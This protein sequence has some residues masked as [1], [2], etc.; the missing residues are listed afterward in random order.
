MNRSSP[1]ESDVRPVSRTRFIF[2]GIIFVGGFL[3]PLLIPLVTNSNLPGNWK[4]IL[5]TGLVAGLPEIGMLLAV[6][7][8]GKQ[9][10]AQLKE[11][12]FARFRKITEPAAVSLTRYR[13]GLFMLFTPLLLGWLQPYATHF[14]SSMASDS[15]L[16]VIILDLIFAT[17][18]IVLGA[19]FWGKIQSLFVHGGAVSSHDNHS[20]NDNSQGES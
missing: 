6:A 11:M 19:E 13:I 17:S 4:A 7:I 16:P 15:I 12:A 9:G 18:F 1:G 5:S 20:S 8:L 10:F 2:G 14:F 3:S